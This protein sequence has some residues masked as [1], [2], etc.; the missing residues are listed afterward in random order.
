M[1]LVFYYEGWFPRI[2]VETLT[3]VLWRPFKCPISEAHHGYFQTPIFVMSL[4][5]LRH[6]KWHFPSGLRVQPSSSLWLFYL[7]TVRAIVFAMIVEEKAIPANQPPLSP[8]LLFSNSSCFQGPLKRQRV[9]GQMYSLAHQLLDHFLEYS[10]QWFGNQ[11]KLSLSGK[12]WHIWRSCSGAL[13]RQNILNL[14]WVHGKCRCS[15]MA[16]TLPVSC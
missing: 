15:Q 1:W 11:S 5:Q 3:F 2:V 9:Q 4:L 6:F 8:S 12:A 10:F 16:L 13:D 7:T 14:N